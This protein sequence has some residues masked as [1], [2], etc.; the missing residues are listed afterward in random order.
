M[1]RSETPPSL[2]VRTH[3]N[4]D[5]RFSESSSVESLKDGVDYTGSINPMRFNMAINAVYQ[6]VAFAVSTRLDDADV[7][8]HNIDE[9]VYV[10][11]TACLP[12]LDDCICLTSSGGF[13]EEIETPFSR[14]TVVGGCVVIQQRFWFLMCFPGCAYIIYQ[15]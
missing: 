4:N 14:G 6:A 9:I 3:Q 7:D 12:G 5:Q 2:Q 13:R 8:A 10:G 15:R 11:G 1:Y